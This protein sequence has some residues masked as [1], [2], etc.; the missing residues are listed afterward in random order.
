MLSFQIFIKKVL[1]GYR[2]KDPYTG[3]YKTQYDFDKGDGCLSISNSKRN[4]DEIMEIIDRV[5]KPYQK[6]EEIIGKPKLSFRIQI[7]KINKKFSE[8]NKKTEKMEVKYEKKS[9]NRSLYNLDI[10]SQPQLMD[11]IKKALIST[12]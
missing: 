10:L 3:K 11:L 4:L 2:V 6:R 12:K 1:S 7:F 9:K 5:L 8:L